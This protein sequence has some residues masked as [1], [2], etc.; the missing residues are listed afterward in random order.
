MTAASSLLES[1]LPLHR[2]LLERLR[3][4]REDLDAR[5]S[6]VT[7]IIQRLETEARKAARDTNGKPPR[8]ARG[9]NAKLVAALF[10][11]P[12]TALSMKEIAERT[13]MSFSSVQRVLKE[14]YVQGEDGLWR[15]TGQ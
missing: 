3:K 5:I 15:K 1:S 11:T 13:G 7:E 4:D 6:Q 8:R 2:D 14:G 9:E 12:S 10:T